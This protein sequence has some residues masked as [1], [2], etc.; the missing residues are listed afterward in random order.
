MK[1]RVTTYSFSCDLIKELAGVIDKEYIKK[2]KD[3]SRLALVFEGKRPTL[4]LRREL[5]ARMNKS[6][7][8]PVF[9]DID[10]L[11]GYIARQDAPRLAV[12]DLEACF[13]VYELARQVSPG[14][15]KG[16]SSFSRFLPWAREIVT[17]I[18]HLDLEG[19]GDDV[20]KNI[21]EKAAIGYEIPP[22]INAVLKNI[23]SLRVQFHQ[24]LRL[25]NMYS[26]G[27]LYQ[28]AGQAVAHV[29]FGEYDEI[30][31]CNI[32]AYQKVQLGILK[33]LYERG[34]ARFFFQGGPDEW[35]VI[36]NIH[37]VLKTEVKPPKAGREEGPKTSLYAA[38]DRH[39]E[40]AAVREILKTVD[41]P[42]RCV[43][44]TPD[45]DT[46]VPLVSEI[47]GAVPALNISM[48][49]PVK[50][51][52]LYALFGAIRAAQESRKD[53]AYY[54]KDYLNAIRHPL[55]K[56][57]KFREDRQV[58]RMLVHSIE[59][60]LTGQ[61]EGKLSGSLF[62]R[63]DDI[64]GSDEA[65][66]RLFSMLGD[67]GITAD[68]TEYKEIISRLHKLILSGWEKIETLGEFAR[69]ADDML[70]VLLTKSQLP[71]YPLDLSVAKKIFS[72][73]S[74]LK[75]P[76][77]GK[78]E[79]KQE[80][81]FSIAA[82][83]IE[84]EKIKF[85]GS[86]LQGLQVL[87]LWESRL[88]AFDT[89][90]VI[91][92]HES[93]LPKL[94][95]YEPLIP[96]EVMTSLG[97]SKPEKEEEIQRY[98]FMRL[99]QAARDVRIAYIDD[100]RTE[101]S[102]F[103]EELIWESQKRSGSLE[104]P[105]LGRARFALEISRKKR[106]AGKTKEMVGMLSRLSFSAT[107]ID[108][109]MNC[110]LKFYYRYALG[111]REKKD[112]LSEMEAKDI[113]D[114]IHDILF[115]AFLPFKCARPVIDAAFR[116]KFFKL[117]DEAFAVT[118][119]KRMPKDAG[120]MREIM[121]YRLKKFLESE[122]DRAEAS[123]EKILF[124][125][126]TF[127]GKMRYKD[128]AFNIQA[129]LDRADELKD[130]SVL[131]VDYKT[132]GQE[133]MPKRYDK[134]RSM[135]LTRDEMRRNVRSFQLPLYLYALRETAGIPRTRPM[136]AALYYLRTSDLEYFL[137]GA[138][139][140]GPNEIIDCFMNAAGC[141]I[142]EILDTGKEFKGDDSNTRYCQMCPYGGMCR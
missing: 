122:T 106:T 139:L 141:L 54:T 101:R 98:H 137:K 79:F 21:Q 56:N 77:F 71:E 35:P 61:I 52:S 13:I 104:S 90:V 44:L 17:F 111:L 76:V 110:P 47:A 142:S 89:V 138:D 41:D 136:N 85:S 115:R 60:L 64:E 125:E 23:E 75:N 87:G 51:S 114:F 84:G 59:E 30:W 55:V 63:L 127:R 7:C 96:R 109:Y 112:I 22:A 69:C 93:V 1:D 80:D 128:T 33:D 126:E 116:K 78:E 73:T 134:I 38:F 20:L 31:F 49:Y 5:A 19:T 39:S 124:L 36:K 32:L 72:V 16:R 67:A 113:G 88:L 10:E 42:D 108:T 15:M 131:I 29:P 50:R 94:R 132:G 34:R 57:I 102:R 121:I 82:D 14:L 68:G 65:R 45:V 9:F 119:Q 86:P 28:E 107:S 83:I 92:A 100:G 103:V 2:G 70:D 74:D 25:G 11:V 6:F 66:E 24:R 27:L 12:S 105:P 97:L 135:P 3:M 40:V 43:I 130:G 62:V 91:D 18:E 123:V 140:E 99:L 117:V 81:V 48:G 4:Y 118:F 46:V 8:P 95:M 58:T 53:G 26:R 37:E 120:I 133:L 129:R